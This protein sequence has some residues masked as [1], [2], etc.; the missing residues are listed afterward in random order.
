M[1]RLRVYETPLARS[2]LRYKVEYLAQ[3][4]WRFTKE[5]L[6]WQDANPSQAGLRRTNAETRFVAFEVPAC[7]YL[8][9]EAHYLRLWQ[10]DYVEAW[11]AFTPDEEFELQEYLLQDPATKIF[12]LEKRQ[13]RMGLAKG[14]SESLEGALLKIAERLEPVKRVDKPN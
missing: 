14:V 7:E 11:G 1:N 3:F 13:R 6:G 5:E 8:G 2:V 12:R 9:V 4:L 10:K